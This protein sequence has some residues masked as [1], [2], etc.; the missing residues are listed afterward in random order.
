MLELRIYRA[1]SGRGDRLLARFEEDTL[2]LFSE[3]DFRVLAFG[4]D[5][6]DRDRICYVLGWS[7]RDEM[8]VQSKCG[9]SPWS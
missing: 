7:S 9:T 1:V 8:N 6:E 3:H 2:R 4:R 5:R